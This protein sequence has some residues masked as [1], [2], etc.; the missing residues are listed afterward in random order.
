M[1]DCVGCK[2]LIGYDQGRCFKSLI[3]RLYGVVRAQPAALITYLDKTSSLSVFVS[4]VNSAT[5]FTLSLVGGR[6][7]R[8]SVVAPRRP[9]YSVAS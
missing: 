4:H 2:N 7:R 8:H 3:R 6:L 5:E 9:Q 1:R